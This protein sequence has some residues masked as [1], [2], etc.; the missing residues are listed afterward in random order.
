MCFNENYRKIYQKANNAGRE[1]KRKQVN[2]RKIH[3][4]HELN[5]FKR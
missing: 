4:L 1:E 5:N 3:K 2:K